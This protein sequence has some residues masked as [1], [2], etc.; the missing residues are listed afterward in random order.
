MTNKN[1]IKIPK[2]VWALGFVSLFMDV[3]SELVHSLLPLFLVSGLG[4]S[5]ISVGIIEGI[6]EATALITKIFSG[7][8]SDYI[9]KRKLITVIG[10]GL[11]ALTKP[12]F[13]LANSV[14]MVLTAR[15]LDRVGK[16]V[17]GAP[18]D[19]L[20]GDISPKEIR[21]ACFGL[22]QSLDTVGAF[23]GPLLAIIFMIIFSNNLRLVMWVAVIPAVLSLVLLVLGVEEPK[24]ETVK[25]AHNP[26]KFS[27]IKNIGKPYWVIV[28]ISAVITLAR[29]SEAFL[30]LKAKD[31]GLSMAYI[32]AIMVLMNIVYALSS[33]PAGV[34]SDKFERKIL[35]QI[36]MLLLII[37]D[38]I[39]AYSSNIFY[40]SVGIVFWGLHMG[41]SQGVLTSMI[42]DTSSDNI[43]GTAYGVFNLVCG[44]AMLFA[45]GIAGVLWE[46]YGSSATFSCGALFALLSF[47]SLLFVNQKHW[48]EKH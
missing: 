16:G 36:A 20:M 22:R 9:G 23:S 45:S 34:L 39:L 12:L 1:I 42:T 4:A 48:F 14:S 30:V 26:I 15:F 5:M 37:A 44:V 25:K 19:A 28:A 17:R 32:P 10:Y 6:A 8:I 11:S 18:R 13:P 31:V 47:L 41:F 29:F 35:L 46:V 40:L 3:S 2:G 24:K 38:V 21:G 27:D 7:T 43:R 33:Y